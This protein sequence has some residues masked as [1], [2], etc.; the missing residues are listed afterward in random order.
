MRVLWF[1]LV[2][3]VAWGF[4]RWWSRRTV[5]ARELTPEELTEGEQHVLGL[6]RE[7]HGE[8]ISSEKLVGQPGNVRVKLQLDPG[9]SEVE[10]LD[11]GLS[12]LARKQREESLSD[13]AIRAGLR[14]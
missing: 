13:A 12:S 11:V 9:K 4:A 7:V 10:S 1:S 2:V 5:R 8:A 6:I 14:F 3:P